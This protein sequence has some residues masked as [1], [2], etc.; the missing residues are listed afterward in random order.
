MI[1]L[2][3]K[4][5]GCRN[6][7]RFWPSRKFLS[8][9]FVFFLLQHKCRVLRCP[10]GSSPV[11]GKCKSL[12]DGTSG[13]YI[14]IPFSLGVIW[15]RSEYKLSDTRKTLRLLGKQI[16]EQ[17]INEAE[18]ERNGSVCPYCYFELQMTADVPR[19][20]VRNRNDVNNDV[21]D[22]VLDINE[23]TKG[24]GNVATES[25]EATKGV[26]NVATDSNEAT[27]GVGN[28]ATESNK[29]QKMNE[30]PTFIFKTVLF[31]L[32]ECQLQNIFDIATD[33]F[34]KIIDIKVDGETEMQLTVGLLKDNLAANQTFKAIKKINSEVWDCK[35]KGAH[36]LK[37]DKFCSKIAITFNEFE[38]HLTKDNR[39]FI[40]SFFE[41]K[42]IETGEPTEVCVDIYYERLQSI[43][44]QIFSYGSAIKGTIA[45]NWIISVIALLRWLNLC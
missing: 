17:V 40:S 27:K 43:D 11:N 14:N 39:E 1:G 25:N 26:G 16:I 5:A 2:I 6:T 4:H 21:T 9:L 44:F 45:F 33:V 12:F 20:A 41:K 15:S 3:T 13:L 35:V 34:G 29:L 22:A 30:V 23:A 18:L 37:D 42:H 7:F 10:F 36:T 19:Q 38:P 24:V 8:V 28:V 32:A 31:T